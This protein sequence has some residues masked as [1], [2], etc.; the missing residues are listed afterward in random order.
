MTIQELKQHCERTVES[1]IAFA[2]HPDDMGKFFHNPRVLEEHQLILQLI[3][4]HE[5]WEEISKDFE[6]RINYPCINQNMMAQNLA[7][8]EVNDIIKKNLGEMIK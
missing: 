2:N 7:Y 8:R 4:E 6:A 1:Q 3:K 5:A